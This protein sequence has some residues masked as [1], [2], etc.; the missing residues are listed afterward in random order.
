MIPKTDNA[1]YV[2]WACKRKVEVSRLPFRRCGSGRHRLDFVT[3]SE[4]ELQRI[5]VI[6]EVLAKRPT[7]ISAARSGLSTKADAP[8][9]DR[10]SRAE[11]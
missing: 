3:M 8:A 9:A 7:D 10:V 2:W 1:A 5:E 11:R 6:S 4:R